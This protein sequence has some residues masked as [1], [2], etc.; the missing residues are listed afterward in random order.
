MTC[1]LQIARILST[2]VSLGNPIIVARLSTRCRSSLLVDDHLW[3]AVSSYR[4]FGAGRVFLDLYAPDS[5]HLIGVHAW[6]SRSHFSCIIDCCRIAQGNFFWTNDLCL[7][8]IFGET[9]FLHSLRIVQFRAT[10][11]SFV[12]LLAFFMEAF[13]N[14][15]VCLDGMLAL[16]AITTFSRSLSFQKLWACVVSTVCFTSWSIWLSVSSK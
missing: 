8:G 9:A 14:S 10:P 13:W 2:I 12:R 3:W 4:Y 5:N 7:W 11:D 16:L 15:Y 1:S 6:S